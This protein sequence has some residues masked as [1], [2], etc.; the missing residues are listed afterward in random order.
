MDNWPWG[1]LA[2]PPVSGTGD[3]WFDSSR[4][5]LR[6]RGAAVL[7]SLM[8]SRPWVRIP[9]ALW[10]RSTRRRTGRG[11]DGTGL[12]QSAG[13][14]VQLASTSL[15]GRPARRWRRGHALAGAPMGNSWLRSR[16]NGQRLCL[17]LREADPAFH[18][19]ADAEHRR[20]HCAVTAASPTVVVRLHPS[21][22]NMG[23]RFFW[24]N[25]VAST[26][27]NPWFPHDPLLNTSVARGRGSSGRTP[28]LHRGGAGSTP[29]VSTSRLGLGGT[30]FES[31]PLEKEA[32]CPLTTTRRGA[33]S[34]P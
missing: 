22:S 31:R 1:S 28:R 23:T 25:T 16:S 2:T 12:V 18:I 11:S 15:Q 24:K 7:A 27:G 30:T 19:L 6:G 21:A 5:D 10:T 9:P 13:P 4:P 34:S 29:A 26:W 33:A 14:N 32:R 20:A 17:R 3:R 8:S